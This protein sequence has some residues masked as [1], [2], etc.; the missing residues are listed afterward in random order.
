LDGDTIRHVRRE[1]ETVVAM[2]EEG[3]SPFCDPWPQWT[4][5]PAWPIPALPSSWS[6]VPS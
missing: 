2:I 4:A 1:A 3:T 5:E 6:V